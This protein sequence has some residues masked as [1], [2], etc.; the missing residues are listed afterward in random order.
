[1]AELSN[2]LLPVA[3]L[4]YVAAMMGYLLE[5]AFGRQ[6]AVARTA[7]RPS[8]ELVTAGAAWLRRG[9]GTA[10]GLAGVAG[11]RRRRSGRSS[12]IRAGRPGSAGWP[13]S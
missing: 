4:V 13:W 11:H 10:R 9:T 8:R 1:M 7:A 3:V 6:G 5:Y 12:S 2:E